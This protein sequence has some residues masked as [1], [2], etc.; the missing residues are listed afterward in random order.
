MRDAIEK[1]RA[2]RESL[3][4]ESNVKEFPSEGTGR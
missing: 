4:S 2:Y 3:E 1:T